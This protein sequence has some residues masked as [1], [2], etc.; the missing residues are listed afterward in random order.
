MKRAFSAE[1]HQTLLSNAILQ[2]KFAFAVTNLV[3]DRHFEFPYLGQFTWGHHARNHGQLK[4]S[5][6]QEKLAASIFEH[7]ATYILALQMDK[8]LQDTVP[9]RFHSP[10]CDVRAAAW[11]ARLIRN[12][13]AHNPLAP[14]WDI[15]PEAQNKTYE[16]VTI[17]KVTTDAVD[18]QP[19]KPLDY[20][21]PLALL[22]L[23]EF[24][25]THTASLGSPEKDGLKA[26]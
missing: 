21:G 5:K 26:N 2:F 7:S 25:L 4:L 18:G 15:P 19:V 11:I 8:A 24:V 3:D 12:T 17:T 13:F 22:T 9:D 6:D 23:A 1:D 14:I 16:V 10:D 20:G